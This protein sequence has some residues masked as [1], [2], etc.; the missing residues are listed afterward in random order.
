M[1][2]PA[3]RATTLLAG[4]EDERRERADAV[5]R[6][7]AALLDDLASLPLSVWP[8]PANF[9]LLRGEDDWLRVRLLEHGIAVRRATTFPGLDGSYVRVAVH[10][11]AEVARPSRSPRCARRCRRVVRAPRSSYPTPYR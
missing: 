9:L 5:A 7:R 1:S 4:A 11:D 3:V 10:P 8:S 2:S 6:A